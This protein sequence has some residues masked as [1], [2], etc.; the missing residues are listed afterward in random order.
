VSTSVVSFTRDLR[1]NDTPA[2]ALAVAG[3]DQVIPVRSWPM[4]R[5]WLGIA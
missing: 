3:V 5:S 4:M 1:V 2:L